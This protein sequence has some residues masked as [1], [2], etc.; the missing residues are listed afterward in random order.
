MAH[1]PVILEYDSEGNTDIDYFIYHT[2]SGNGTFGKFD[3]YTQ[4]KENT[5]YVHQ[6]S[7]DFNMRNSPS[8]ASLKTP[9]KATKVKF[10]VH[11]GK[12]D[13]SVVMKCSSSKRTRK[14][15]SK[16]SC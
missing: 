16:N 12:T 14:T 4:T 8:I 9:V 11:S 5:E 7:Y 6:G 13:M 15:L 1:F 10:E 3:V 2:N